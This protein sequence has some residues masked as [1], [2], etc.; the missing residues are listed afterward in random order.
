MKP[1]RGIAG[2]LVALVAALASVPVA[3]A[4]N[5]D[6]VGGYPS[7]RERAILALTNACR[8]DPVRYRDTFLGTRKILLPKNYPAVAPITHSAAL[9]RAA[10]EH[11]RD[12]ATTPC[13]QHNSCDGTSLW[14]RIKKHYKEGGAMAENIAH[15]YASPLD[16]VNGWILDK[17]APDR[18]KGDGHRKNLMSPKY[19]EVG[20]GSVPSD[21][22]RGIYDTQDFGD[23]R[24]DFV[25]PVASGSH[26]LP[27]RGR[28]TFLASFHAADGKP[29]REAS[30]VLE[31]RTHEM[32]RAFGKASSATWLVELAED[33]ECR[34]YV[35]RF[36]DAAGKGWRYPENGLLYTTGEGG[37][38]REYA[39]HV[40]DDEEEEDEADAEERMRKT[41]TD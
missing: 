33:D 41:G 2:P 31:G 37:C 6:V 14:T 35:F 11:S 29:P 1:V 4:G 27:G 9:S 7:Y 16:V 25:S 17:G 13:F 24:P 38:R 15:G 22:R 40:G 12:M 19:R 8:Q 3:R 20:H 30:L 5:G 26:V 18:S 36:R 23:G 10:R 34:S 39:P 21:A 28:I 32:T